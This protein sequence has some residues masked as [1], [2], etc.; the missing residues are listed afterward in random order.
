MSH[1]EI[2]SCARKVTKMCST[3]RV[4][5]CLCV[6]VCVRARVDKAL[7]TLQ[8]FVKSAKNL[9]TSYRS[10]FMKFHRSLFMQFH[11]SLPEI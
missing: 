3:L 6:C 9:S 11:R 5:V 10:L 8:K 1:I 2:S 7:S 4:C